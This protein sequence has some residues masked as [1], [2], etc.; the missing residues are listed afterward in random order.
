MKVTVCELSDNE[1]NFIDDW[2]QLQIHL[3]ENRPDL[4]LLP[5]LAFCKWI[6]SDKGANNATKI[7][8]AEEHERWMLKLEQLNVRR[9]VYSKPVILNGNFFNTAFVFE[10]GIGHSKIH[11]KSFFPEEPFFWERSIYD[12]EEEMKFEVLDLGD[13]KVGALL[14]TEMWFTEHAR[15][16]GKEGIDILL[17]PRATGM[18][19]VKRWLMCGQML[20]IISGA[21]CLSSNK[22]GPGEDGFKWG[23]NGWIAEPVTGN[24]L[25]V[26]S[27]E[28]KFITIDID[29]NKS[30][31]AKTEY[32]LY[33]TE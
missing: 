30:R 15:Q 22:S 17:C 25:G 9:I 26:T 33:V 5:E 20:S 32:P 21:Y 18:E 12:Q 29:I 2:K 7:R 31:I 24:L 23:G 8:S 14:C 16:Y 27:N 4:L 1:N 3:D 10:K 11:T 13:I 19:S 6:A 28:K